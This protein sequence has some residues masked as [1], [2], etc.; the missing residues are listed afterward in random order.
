MR[1]YLIAMMA[2]LTLSLTASSQTAEE[3]IERTSRPREDWKR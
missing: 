2:I 1:N 3:L